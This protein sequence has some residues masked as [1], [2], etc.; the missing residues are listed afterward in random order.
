MV[1]GEKDKESYAD[2]FTDYMLHDDVDD[3]GN[4]IELEIHKENLKVIDDDDEN[5]EE[6]K[7]DEMCSLENRTE[8]MQ[9][10]IPITPRS[11]RINLSS[12]KHIIQELTDTISVSTATKSKYPHKKIR[13]SNKYVHLPGALRRMCRCQG[14]IIRDMERKVKRHKTSKSSKSARGSSSKQSSKESITYVTKQQHQQQEWDAYEE[15]TVTDEDE[16]IPKDETPE[17]II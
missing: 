15:E 1:K 7:D 10:Q 17:L 11:S 16:V 12:N 3:S 4:R 13:I 14:Y 5:E 8:K 9:T 2:K 6:K